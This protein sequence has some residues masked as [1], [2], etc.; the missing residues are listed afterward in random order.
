MEYESYPFLR[1]LTL[2]STEDDGDEQ[3]LYYGPEPLGHVKKATQLE[4]S[5]CYTPHSSAR[6][7][8]T[9]VVSES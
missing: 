3:Y 7:H 5:P 6:K 8:C 9:Q 4:S 2:P 1:C